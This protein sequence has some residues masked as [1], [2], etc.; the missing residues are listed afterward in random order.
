MSFLGLILVVAFFVLRSAIP[1][2]RE[3]SCKENM[4][5]CKKKNGGSE[6]MVWENLSHQFFSSL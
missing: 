2:E 3:S 4:D 5:C 6:K 1:A